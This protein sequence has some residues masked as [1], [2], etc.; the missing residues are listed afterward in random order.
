MQNKK[1]EG[2]RTN[3][4]LLV[5]YSKNILILLLLYFTDNKKKKCSGKHYMKISIKQLDNIMIAYISL[6]RSI[7]LAC[8]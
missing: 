3:S 5:T 7:S 2:D 6:L 8:V 1:T 4:M